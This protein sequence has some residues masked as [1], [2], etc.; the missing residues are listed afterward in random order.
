MSEFQDGIE[1]AALEYVASV[2]QLSA[3]WEAVGDAIN[4]A[5]PGWEGDYPDAITQLASEIARLREE[6]PEEEM[7]R[8]EGH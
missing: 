7:G 4:A 1:K 8:G 3:H 2:R 5:L 6:S